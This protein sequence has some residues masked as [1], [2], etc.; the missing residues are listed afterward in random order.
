V[1]DWPLRIRIHLLG[2]GLL[3][4]VGPKYVRAHKHASKHKS[5]ILRSKTC[6][7]FYCLE[8]FDP[9]EISGWIDDD[10]TAMCP[11][12]GIDSVIG[13]ASRYPVSRDFLKQM[14]RY[15]FERS[16]TI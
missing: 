10:Q 9:S 11:R 13:V 2:T 4:L 16:H 3:K 15:W 5:E 1:S 8:N 6:G 7:C 12:C 14:R